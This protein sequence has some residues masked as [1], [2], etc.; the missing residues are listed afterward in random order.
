MNNPEDLCQP[1]YQPDYKYSSFDLERIELSRAIDD[2]ELMIHGECFRNEI[3]RRTVIEVS[4]LVAKGKQAKVTESTK[5][6][7]THVALV[8]R[9]PWDWMKWLIV[10]FDPTLN[11]GWLKPDLIEYNI[12]TQQKITNTFWNVYP[13]QPGNFTVNGRWP[14]KIEWLTTTPP[15]E[16]DLRNAKQKAADNAMFMAAA[17]YPR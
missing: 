16:E 10:D 3:M 7:R 14:D 11:F 12:P 13:L 4:A 6:I 1:D 2:I 15:T 8:P 5:T 9:T 17:F